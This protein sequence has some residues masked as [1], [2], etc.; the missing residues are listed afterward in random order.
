VVVMESLAVAALKRKRLTVE[1][2]PNESV[3]RF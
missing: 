1:Y 2:D 3:G